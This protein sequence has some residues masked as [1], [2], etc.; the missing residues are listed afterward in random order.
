MIDSDYFFHQISLAEGYI[1]NQNYVEHIHKTIDIYDTLLS[2]D[3]DFN[4]TFVNTILSKLIDLFKNCDNQTRFMI[5]NIL[6][7]YQAK[8][9]EIFIK[10]EIVN[11]IIQV[12]TCNDSTSRFYAIQLTKYLPFLFENRMDLIYN[13][14]DLLINK[15]SSNEKR[16]IIELIQNKNKKFNYNK[17]FLKEIVENFEE[18]YENFLNDQNLKFKFLKLIDTSLKVFSFNQVSLFFKKCTQIYHTLL[19]I[20]N[21]AIGIESNLLITILALILYKI[22]SI[23]NFLDRFM[24]NRLLKQNEIIE[25]IFLKD[26]N[27]HTFLSFLYFVDINQNTFEELLSKYN[28][29]TEECINLIKSKTISVL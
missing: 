11:S 9:N 3:I 5:N 10:G 19:N 29:L 28:Y 18:I 16:E 6:F 4:K 20:L 1:R 14:I 17:I 26:Q 22:S 24:V 12:L 25:N 23:H 27:F 7:K 8:F 13:L 15:S 21:K 2:Y